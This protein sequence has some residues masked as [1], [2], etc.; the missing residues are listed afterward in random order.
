MC[1]WGE[2]NLKSPLP[3][4]PRMLVLPVEWALII[5]KLW[6]GIVCL[7]RNFIPWGPLSGG[8]RKQPLW[9]TKIHCAV[10]VVAQSMYSTLWYCMEQLFFLILRNARRT[11]SYNYSNKTFDLFFWKILFLE[12]LLFHESSV[13]YVFGRYEKHIHNHNMATT[14]ASLGPGFAQWQ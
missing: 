2:I 12:D 9:I 7:L 5:R 14:H 10:A 8:G 11:F 1:V 13:Q 3:L 6:E 4:S